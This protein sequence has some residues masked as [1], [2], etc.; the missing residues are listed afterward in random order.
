[1]EKST[2]ARVVFMCYD[3]VQVDSCV[4]V[5]VH[6]CLCVCMHALVY[7]YMHVCKHVPECV[8]VLIDLSC[9]GLS[10]FHLICNV[11]CLQTAITFLRCSAGSPV[12]GRISSACTPSFWTRRMW[13]RMSSSTPSA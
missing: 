11:T 1:M 9:I 6:L 2:L 5:Y 3:C 8:S 12:H 4:C 13:T 10:D 7:A